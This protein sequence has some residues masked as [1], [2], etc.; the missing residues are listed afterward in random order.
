MKSIKKLLAVLLFF[1]SMEISAQN[2]IVLDEVIGV[3]GNEIVTKA[4]VEAKYAGM[5]N[6]GMPITDNSRCEVF[7]DVLFTKMLLNQAKVDSIEVT[8][9][10]V[11]GEM[12]RRLR[13][14]V[15]QFGSEEALVNYYKKPITQIRTEMR[16]ALY[17]QLLIQGMQAKLTSNISVTPSEVEDFYKRIP[18]DS[19]PLIDAEIEIAQII[20][21][22]PI[23]RASNQEAKDRL[24]EFK[25]RVENGEKFSTLAVLYSEDQGSAVK[26]GE[27]GFVG[28]AEVEP[29]FGAASFKLKEG[30]V[31]PIIETRYGFHIIQLIERR[32][33]RVNVRHI[34]IRPKMDQIGL[35]KAKNELDSI[36]GMIQ[37]GVI[38]F[39]QAAKKFTDD[40]D[41]RNNG[42]L[43]LNPYDA[44][45]LI[46]MDELDPALFL[47]IDKMDIGEIS[48]IVEI[49]TPG[50][51]PGYKIVKLNKRTKPHRASLEKDYQKVKSA[52]IAEKEQNVV[53]VW[54]TGA[55]DKTYIKLDKKYVDNC[56]FR[57]D[58]SPFV[59]KDEQ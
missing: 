24:R 30:Q 59:E 12:N 47:V 38:T 33:D 43:L 13:Y 18:E 1:G 41:S 39:E 20:K 32:G 54:V 2:K 15:S 40:E 34:L 17:E 55:M 56:K 48:Q 31:S 28:R 8:E 4:E 27:I 52:A 36:A 44:S 25:Q 7:E 11:D 45:S 6:Q 26:G 57:Q 51:K 5:I 53:E 49:T 16:D 58:W 21:Y 35:E 50:S 42:G 29:E 10:Q 37:T 22:A 3:I 9:S 23:S 14:F 46:P 19:L